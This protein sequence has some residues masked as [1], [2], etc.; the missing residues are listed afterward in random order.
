MSNGEKFEVVIIDSGQFDKAADCT[1]CNKSIYGFDGRYYKR[2]NETL[3]KGCFAELLGEI[4]DQH[5][6]GA[7]HTS[8]KAPDTYL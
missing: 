4:I 5:P 8:P 1:K 3:D 7:L 6:I 2:G